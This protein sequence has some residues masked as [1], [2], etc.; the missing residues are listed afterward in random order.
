VAKISKIPTIE[1]LNHQEFVEK[2]EKDTHVSMDAA[3][4]LSKEL[5]EETIE[6][7]VVFG[8]IVSHPDIYGVNKL[9]RN[10]DKTLDFITTEEQVEYIAKST[11]YDLWSPKE[12]WY[13]FDHENWG[14]GMITVGDS[15]FYSPELGNDIMIGEQQVEE[16]EVIETEYGQLDVLDPETN[17]ANKAR[18]YTQSILENS[19]VKTNDLSDMGSMSL[20]EARKNNVYDREVLGEKLYEFTNGELPFERMKN[21]MQIRIDNHIN[22]DDWELLIK[23]LDAIEEEFKKQKAI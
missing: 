10:T 2:Y 22:L 14:I 23:E 21:D 1:P 12:N 15:A 7:S 18:R 5:Q 19:Y 8:S 20:A 3:L 9:K 6:D 16:P 13:F 4:E 11:D 17:Y